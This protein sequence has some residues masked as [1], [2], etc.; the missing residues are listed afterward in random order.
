MDVDRSGREFL[1]WLKKNDPFLFEVT[2]R[3][4]KEQSK[5]DRQLGFLGIDFSSFDIGSILKTAASVVKDVAPTVIQSKQQYDLLKAQVKRAETGLPPLD[6]NAYSVIPGT[7]QAYNPSL[8]NYNPG[9]VSQYAQQGQTQTNYVPWILGAIGL[10]GL[11]F[12][13]KRK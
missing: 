2:M 4:H 9:V 6:V 5:G 10:T 8:V 1:T 11:I 12:L 7:T 3:R 13:L